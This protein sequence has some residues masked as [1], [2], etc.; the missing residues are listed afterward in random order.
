MKFDKFL[1]IFDKSS[2]IE[3]NKAERPSIKP[4][5]INNIKMHTSVKNTQINEKQMIA[6][7]EIMTD[8]L[9]AISKLVEKK[10]NL[11]KNL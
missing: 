4:N 7:E 1:D 9:L 5:S 6:P 3:K 2:I 8:P 10:H 11:A